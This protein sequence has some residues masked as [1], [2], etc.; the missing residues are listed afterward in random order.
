MRTEY[1]AAVVLAALVAGAGLAAQSIQS[2]A[3]YCPQPSAS[4]VTALFAPCRTFDAATDH[5]SKPEVVRMGL[6][7]PAEQRAP[8]ATRLAARLAESVDRFLSRSGG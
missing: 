4:S 7:T 5:V 2:Q 3:D 8:P 6:L 1:L